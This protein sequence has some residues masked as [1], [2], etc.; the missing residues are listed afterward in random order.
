MADTYG[1]GNHPKPSG[2]CCLRNWCFV[3]A[4]DAFLNQ[5]INNS[6]Q[7]LGF[8]IYRQLP[9]RGW[10]LLLAKDLAK[11]TAV[12]PSRIAAIGYCFGGAGA[13]ELARSG[14]EVKAVVVFHADLTSPTPE[15]DKNIKGRVLA[16][17]GA[18]DPIVPAVE[19]EKFENEMRTAHVDWQ[20]IS[21][22]GAVHCFT[23][24]HAGND[25]AH[26]CAYNA[27]AEQR[28]WRATLDFFRE[29]L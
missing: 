22:G 15:D 29:A 5:V 3:N 2:T 19:R 13:L 10:Q 1:K 12:D 23:D 26:G 24:A 4:L 14:A 11:I 25:L 16:L 20:L 27:Q 28:S 8:I 9:I 17:H 21:Y 6:F 7:I 18:D